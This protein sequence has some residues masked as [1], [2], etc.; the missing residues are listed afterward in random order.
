MNGTGTKGHAVTLGIAA[1]ITASLLF[2]G[3]DVCAKALPGW[4]RGDHL[5]PRG[6]RP[7]LS[8]LHR[9]AG[10]TARL[11]RPG[12][13]A[14]PCAGPHRRAGHPALFLFPSGAE[15]GRCGD[16]DGAVGI[17]H[18]PP[19]A[20]FLRNNPGR[21]VMVPL[22]IIA[23]GAAVV[24]QVWN[25]DSFNGYA[26]FGLGSA[27]SSALAYIAIGRLT[28]EPG[29]HSGTELVFYFQ[30]YSMLC[31]AVLLPFGFVMPEGRVAVDTGTLRDGHRGADG[32]HLGMPA[33]AFPHHFLRD[34]H[35]HPLPHPRG[36]ALLGRG[37][38]GVFMDRRCGHR[39]RERPPPVAHEIGKTPK[40]RG[41]FIDRGDRF[42]YN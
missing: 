34:V 39:R 30:L 10:G 9:P 2:T 14:A 24:L 23:A 31:G 33:R 21:S 19:R 17:F 25:F 7:A 20:V 26:L 6:H 41:F 28:E 40:I 5:P 36:L 29:R 37:A 32:L 27:L 13:G 16:P 35:G 8:A 18:V 12:H 3:M 15:A 1:A 22:G 4:A 11:F 38:H 42:Y